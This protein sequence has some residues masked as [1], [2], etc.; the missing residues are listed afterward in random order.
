[1]FVKGFQRFNEHT[2]TSS[3]VNEVVELSDSDD[4]AVQALPSPP[5][6]LL[7]SDDEVVIVEES[8]TCRSLSEPSPS[9]RVCTLPHETSPTSPSS[10]AECLKPSQTTATLEPSCNSS[11]ELSMLPRETSPP[12]P[13]SPAE[14]PRPF[15]TTATVES[16]CGSS[17]ELSTLP[18]DT[19][20]SSPAEC[21][22]RS[23]TTAT[24]EPSCSF[25]P[26]SC[27]VD[28]GAGDQ[29]KDLEEG[30]IKEDAMDVDKDRDVSSSSARAETDLTGLTLPCSQTTIA[31]PAHSMPAHYSPPSFFAS[32]TSLSSKSLLDRISAP[33]PQQPETAKRPHKKKK[34]GRQRGSTAGKLVRMLRAGLDP[35]SVAITQ[36]HGDDVDMEDV[37]GA[38]SD[39][40]PVP[41]GDWP[42][43]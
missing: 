28:H 12:L 25:D 36:Q 31:P 26:Q 43:L 17:I 20:P 9:I 35:A 8:R 39:P 37:T 32:T 42:W 24:L 5:H 22:R 33:G 40:W 7:Q 41:A 6:E 29:S 1:M 34:G 23:Q 10:P 2:L 16:I 4:E 27:S 14:C 11:I 38:L 18:R 19:S 15:Q 3:H 13:S 30:E 21:L